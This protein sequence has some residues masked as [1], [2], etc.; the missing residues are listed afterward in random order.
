MWNIENGTTKTSQG[1][2]EKG[3]VRPNTFRDSTAPGAEK[4]NNE[5]RENRAGSK[6]SRKNVGER[7][8]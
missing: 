8:S 5:R 7:K 1:H 4:T 3:R 6:K 2:L